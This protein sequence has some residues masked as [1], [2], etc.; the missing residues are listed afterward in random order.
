M[1][2]DRAAVSLNAV[3]GLKI[4]R[5]IELKQ[6]VTGLG[7]KYKQAPVQARGNHCTV[8]GERCSGKTVKALAAA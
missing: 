8:D 1:T 6:D 2:I 7:V 3:D 4:H 5:C